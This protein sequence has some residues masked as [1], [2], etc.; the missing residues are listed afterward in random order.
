M[1]GVCLDV[2]HAGVVAPTGRNL[3]RLVMT[4]SPDNDTRP[5]SGHALELMHALIQSSSRINRT[6]MPYAAIIFMKFRI[7]L[8]QQN[9]SRLDHTH[10]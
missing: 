6:D 9:L 3:Q 2:I 10:A 4:G 8:I 1:A 7:Q 5:V